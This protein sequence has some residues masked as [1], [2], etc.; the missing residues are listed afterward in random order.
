LKLLYL[1]G[2]DGTRVPYATSY[3]PYF[4][5]RFNELCVSGEA[6]G[7]SFTCKPIGDQITG[8]EVSTGSVSAWTDPSCT[9][10]L[11]G[12]PL[13]SK[14]FDAG[15]AHYRSLF[16]PA[17]RPF[18][19]VGSRFSGT[20]YLSAFGGGVCHPAPTD[21]GFVFDQ[22]HRLSGEYY[23]GSNQEVA[24]SEFVKFGFAR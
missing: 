7:F 17:D 6:D 22:T 12:L 18:R 16:D 1:V 24:D 4:D 3:G 8:N 10:P 23:S 11:V 15:V 5:S 2:P 21:G 19:A 9:T 13:V 20:V 14:A